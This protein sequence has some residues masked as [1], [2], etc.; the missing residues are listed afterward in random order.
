MSEIELQELRDLWAVRLTEF[1][2]SGQSI[3]KWCKERDLKPHQLQYRLDK[4]RRT[5]KAS[6]PQWVS[7]E[8][9]D[10][11]TPPII[12]KIGQ[13]TVEVRP[14]FDQT[15]LRDLVGTLAP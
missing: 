4:R 2:A 12:L 15:L 6:V 13:V 3:A 8:P 11:S 9:K 10:A 14:G 5:A 1:D 7:L